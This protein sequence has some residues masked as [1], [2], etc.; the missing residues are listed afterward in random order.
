M[1]RCFNSSVTVAPDGSVVI[2]IRKC[3]LARDRAWCQPGDA[4]H[5][6][7][8]DRV[9]EVQWGVC[10]DI[11]WE[12]FTTF[13]SQ[14][15]PS[16]VI[17]SMAWDSGKYLADLSDPR[18]P[19]DLTTYNWLIAMDGL[20]KRDAG[21]PVIVIFANRCGTEG[22]SSYTGSSAVVQLGC[23]GGLIYKQLGCGEE[24]CLIV[25]TEAQSELAR[26]FSRCDR[27][28]RPIASPPFQ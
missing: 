27:S 11:M 8:I 25:D 10:S 4:L 18:R 13:A 12:G 1:S 16:L 14:I 17:V 7:L 22:Y 3:Y 28:G 23:G 5:S 20:W 24:A 9:G 6:R 15:Q 19:S 2:N 26:T 21:R